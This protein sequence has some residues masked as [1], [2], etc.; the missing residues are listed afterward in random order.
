[1]VEAAR[2]SPI[3]I[4]DGQGSD[5]GVQGIGLS[6]SGLRRMNSGER[7]AY[8]GQKLQKQQSFY[9][10]AKLEG[11]HEIRLP[12]ERTSVMLRQNEIMERVL[13]GG[14]SPATIADSYK[15]DGAWVL[16]E[17]KVGF[18]RAWNRSSLQLQDKFPEESII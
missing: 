2:T 11:A 15:T 17:F 3:P 4:P 12:H 6:N 13:V 7:A 5:V 10:A 16:S 14:E 9:Q 8:L 18:I 1:M